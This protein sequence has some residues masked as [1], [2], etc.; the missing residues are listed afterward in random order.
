MKVSISNKIFEKFPDAVEYIVIARGLNIETRFG[1]DILEESRKIEAGLREK[2]ADLDWLSLPQ[3][4]LWQD[5]YQMVLDNIS[6]TT[7]VTESFDASHIALTKRVMS[8][9]DLP[10]INALVNFYNSYSVKYGLPFGGE[11]LAKVVGDLQLDFATG[12]EPYL[13]IG[14]AEVG[15]PY[16]G[17]PV[18]KDDHSVTCRMWGWRQSERTAVTRETKDAYFVIDFS[19]S[20]SKGIEV[21]IEQVVEEF[22]KNLQKYFG[23]VTDVYR[24]D[25]NSQHIVIEYDQSA[26]INAYDKANPRE[27]LQKMVAKDVAKEKGSKGIK[28][29]RAENMGL[30]K[31]DSIL[32]LIDSELT[33]IVSEAGLAAESL[34]FQ[35]CANSEMG[36]FSSTAAMR[37]AG[38]LKKSPKEIAEELARIIN[39]ANLDW[40]SELTVAP[41]NFINLKVNN[42]WLIENAAKAGLNF[43]KFSTATAGQERVIL[44]ES[45]SPNPNKPLHIGHLLNLFLGTSLLRM[46]D[47]VG[48]V[49]EQ[50]SIINDRGMPIVKTIWALDNLAQ[51]GTPD[52]EGLKPDQFVGKYY[53]LGSQKYKDDN[54]VKEQIKGMLAK[55][56]QGDPEIRATWRK[57]IDW[58]LEG[59]LAT[60]GRVWEDFGHRWYESEIYTSGRDTIMNYLDGTKI[61]KL[62]D[63]AIVGRIEDEYGVPDVVL[64]KSDGTS[65]YH[66]QDIHLTTLKIEKFKPWRAM[67]VVGNEQIMHFQRLFSLLD[68]LEL[69]PID[70]LYHYA[71]GYVYGKD[72]KKMSSRDGQALSGDGLLDKMHEAA[73]KAVQERNVQ[74]ESS[75]SEEEIAEVVAVNALKF[76]FLVTDPFKDMRFDIEKAVSFTGK[77]GPYIMYAYARGKSILRGQ[78]YEPGTIPVDMGNISDSMTELDHQLLM[79][80]L[81][82][83]ERFVS[84]ANNYAPSIVAEYIYDLA[85]LFNNFYERESIQNANESEKAVRLLA[86]DL[87][88]QVLADGMKLLGMKPLEQM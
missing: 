50:D 72:G 62:E 18:W 66:T 7:K 67:W 59:Q 86:V 21:G 54:D 34:Y 49:G 52:S 40:I 51:G 11:D 41:N 47:K 13:G 22:A 17:E 70:N 55:W 82:Y 76:A 20:L 46:F 16:V 87:V 69:I 68:M 36:D 57:M 28:K 9:K 60:A 65:L 39:D 53:V 48:F 81:E 10:N 80:A 58:V 84:A 19:E 38:E 71:Y 8:D 32:S 35:Y 5:R 37:L 26:A 31:E 24:L 43:A 75:M 77:S 2:Y 3:Y 12:D 14:E 73:V 6:Q 44:V 88:T 85:K 29:R 30:V 33:K 63:G 83:Q 78:N 79:K 4:K 64:L 56:E 61:E 74:M 27:D 25:N 23:A 1:K 45:P 42:A 15:T